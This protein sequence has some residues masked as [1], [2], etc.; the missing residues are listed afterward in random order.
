MTK[1]IHIKNI[2]II[3]LLLLLITFPVKANNDYKI[4]LV[5]DHYFAV[6]FKNKKKEIELIFPDG[7]SRILTQKRSASG[8]RF[9]NENITFWNKGDQAQIYINDIILDAKVKKYSEEVSKH[10]PRINKEEYIFF[11]T[12]GFYIFFPEFPDPFSLLK[13]R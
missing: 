13:D 12:Q 10:F 9:T 11:K 2:L 7:Q 5:K 1:K 8:I 3:I 4:F 6:D